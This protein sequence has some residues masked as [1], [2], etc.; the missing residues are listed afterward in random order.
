MRTDQDRRQIFIDDSRYQVAGVYIYIQY[1]GE[2]LMTSPQ[3]DPNQSFPKS[4]L[5]GPFL[6]STTH[7]RKKCKMSSC[8]QSSRGTS[9]SVPSTRKATSAKNHAF[10]SA[11]V[12]RKEALT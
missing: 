10:K 11:M 12:R 9:S 2:Q 6:Q 1:R 4:A 7:L 8:W 3:L 5:V